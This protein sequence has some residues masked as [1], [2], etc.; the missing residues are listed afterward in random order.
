MK[1]SGK[2]TEEWKAYTLIN[3]RIL[4]RNPYLLSRIFICFDQPFDHD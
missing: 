1:L 2:R 4:S 3:E